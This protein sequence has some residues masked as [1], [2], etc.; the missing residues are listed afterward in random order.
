MRNYKPL[1]RLVVDHTIILKHISKNYKQIHLTK[2]C[3]KVIK[4]IFIFLFSDFYYYY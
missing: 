1:T 2:V 4:V 3:Q